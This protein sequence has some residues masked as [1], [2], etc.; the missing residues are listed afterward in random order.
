M[1]YGLVMKKK[2]SIGFI[3]RLIWVY[4]TRILSINCNFRKVSKKMY[5]GL[6]LIL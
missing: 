4:S 5:K 3:S 1:Y 6:F 2:V